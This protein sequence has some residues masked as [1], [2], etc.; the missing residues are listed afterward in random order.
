MRRSADRRRSTGCSRFGEHW[1]KS[2]EYLIIEAFTECIQDAGIGRDEIEAFRE[3][4]IVGPAPSSV[5]GP[6]STFSLI[7]RQEGASDAG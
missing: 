5:L 6:R 7:Q 3:R 4:K 2:A 1:D